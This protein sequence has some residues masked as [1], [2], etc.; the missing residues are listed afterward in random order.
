LNRAQAEDPIV[1]E[2]WYNFFATLLEAK[3][4][5]TNDINNFDEPASL[6]AMDEVRILYPKPLRSVIQLLVNHLVLQ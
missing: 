4:I 3:K 1:I 6:L 2:Q 5:H